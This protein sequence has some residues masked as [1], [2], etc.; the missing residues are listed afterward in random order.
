LLH[1][2]GEDLE[3]NAVHEMPVRDV[4]HVFRD[5]GGEHDTK[6]IWES[7][8]RLAK[9]TVEWRLTDGDACYE[10]I[11]ALFRA[12]VSRTAKAAGR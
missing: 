4:N 10:G 3:E 5:L 8:R 9:T 2:V 12:E 1:A 7:A 11:A 6:W